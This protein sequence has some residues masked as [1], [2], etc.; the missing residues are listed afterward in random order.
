MTSSLVK[1]FDQDYDSRISKL[2]EGMAWI[3][4]N[5]QYITH[6]VPFSWS[7]VEQVDKRI[8]SLLRGT[9]WSY[10]VPDKKLKVSYYSVF[11]ILSKS[12][13]LFVYQISFS[14][15][16]CVL[17]RS[18]RISPVI[19]EASFYVCKSAA[20]KFYLPVHR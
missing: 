13:L 5:L 17:F 16:S 3:E 11:S 4:P 8:W 18:F 15:C 9:N 19:L 1:T 7:V 2:L 20:V 6:F 14:E 10:T 12:N